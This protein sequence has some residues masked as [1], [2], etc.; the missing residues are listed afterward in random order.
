MTNA[1][2]WVRV[3]Q[4]CTDQAD[5]LPQRVWALRKDGHEAAMALKGGAWHRR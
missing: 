2:W 5:L 1:D 4:A 3:V